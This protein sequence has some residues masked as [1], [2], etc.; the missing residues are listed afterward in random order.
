MQTHH[1][2][3]LTDDVRVTTADVDRGVLARHPHGSAWSGKD[4]S[5]GQAQAGS[6]ALPHPRP[7]PRHGCLVLSALLGAP[8]PRWGPIQRKQLKRKW[9][10]LGARCQTRQAP[11]CSKCTERK[12]EPA[13][14]G[15]ACPRA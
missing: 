4:Q 7:H 9:K 6:P 10:G 15:S 5:D 1:I 13:D 11:L 2:L 12:T 14:G 8:P 3:G